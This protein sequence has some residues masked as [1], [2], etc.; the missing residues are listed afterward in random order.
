MSNASE[1]VRV[2]YPVLSDGMRGLSVQQEMQ[3]LS[4]ELKAQLDVIDDLLADCSFGGEGVPREFD[5]AHTMM[6]TA[7][8]LAQGIHTLAFESFTGVL[9]GGDDG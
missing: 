9:D 6:D 3:R 5:L 7:R 2:R 1:A 8:R 4:S